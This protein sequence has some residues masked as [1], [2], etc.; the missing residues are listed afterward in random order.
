MGLREDIEEVQAVQ[1]G[2]DQEDRQLCEEEH[3]DRRLEVHLPRLEKVIEEDPPDRGEVKGYHIEDQITAN[4]QEHDH[5]E[6]EPYN[7]QHHQSLILQPI[8]M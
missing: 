8:A 1:T 7:G 3:A 4:R 6:G 2:E 5:G